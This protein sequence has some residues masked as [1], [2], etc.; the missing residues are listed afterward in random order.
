MSV[1]IDI[2]SKYFDSILDICS[3]FL[4]FILFYYFT[5]I[6]FDF[7]FFLVFVSCRSLNNN[8]CYQQLNNSNHPPISTITN[9]T[10]STKGGKS[11]MELVHAYGSSSVWG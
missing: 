7:I 9:N 4:S 8:G 3:L 6:L 1:A 5:L 11:T 2:D 10:T